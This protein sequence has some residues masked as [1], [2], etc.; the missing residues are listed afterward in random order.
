[1]HYPP[2][3]TSPSRSFSLQITF[4]KVT[5]TVFEKISAK[6]LY[7]AEAVRT[8]LRF[9][10]SRRGSPTRFLARLP[11]A[12]GKNYERRENAKLLSLENIYSLFASERASERV[13]AEGKRADQS[14]ANLQR[15]TTNKFSYVRRSF[16]KFALAKVASR[17]FTWR[18]FLFRRWALPFSGLT[19]PIRWISPS[20]RTYYSSSCSRPGPVPSEISIISKSRSG[21]AIRPSIT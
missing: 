18:I 12:R 3:T 1:M 5:S 16:R 11:V 10:E 20:V 21:P 14:P 7:A 4:I 8:S 17:E 2:V 9:F 6:I 19:V 13:K 15:F